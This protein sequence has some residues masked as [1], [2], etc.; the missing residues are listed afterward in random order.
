M[1]GLGTPQGNIHACIGK[2][3]FEAD[4]IE[5]NLVALVRALYDVKPKAVGGQVLP[6]CFS[7]PASALFSRLPGSRVHLS[8]TQRLQGKGLRAACLP[9]AARHVS[10]HV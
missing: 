10:V 7:C 6:L 1:T 4:K 8:W 2:V 9:F 5:A 3:D